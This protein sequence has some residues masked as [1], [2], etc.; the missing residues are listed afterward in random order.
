[1]ITAYPLQIAGQRIRRSFPEELPL[2]LSRFNGSLTSYR[3][4]QWRPVQRRGLS[5]WYHDVL[6]NERSN[7]YSVCIVW[8][9]VNESEKKTKKCI[10]NDQL[11]CFLYLDVVIFDF[12]SRVFRDVLR[13]IQIFEQIG[14]IRV[15]RVNEF[16]ERLFSCFDRFE[17]LTQSKDKYWHCCLMRGKKSSKHFHQRQRHSI[18]MFH[19]C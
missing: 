17:N 3:P 1:M 14:D 11:H 18:L 10:N 7:C 13:K 2:S 8:I 19:W 16:H 6:V 4:C 15:L 12:F 5:A 9:S